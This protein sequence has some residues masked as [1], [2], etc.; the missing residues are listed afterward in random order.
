MVK[1]NHLVNQSENLQICKIGGNIRNKIKKRKRKNKKGGS[2]NS[3]L[4]YIANLFSI[5]ITAVLSYLTNKGKNAVKDYVNKE[6]PMTMKSIEIIS[7]PTKI[8]SNLPHDIEDFNN[9]IV[10]YPYGEPNT[11]FIPDQYDWYSFLQ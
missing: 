3:I 5:P 4:E 7:N 11:D 9:E 1:F 10:S 8:I 2:L 6:Y